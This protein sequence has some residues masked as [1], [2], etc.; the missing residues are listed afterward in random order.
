VPF[1]LALLAPGSDFDADAITGLGGLSTLAPMPDAFIV[2]EVP[3]VADVPEVGDVPEVPELLEEEV[4]TLSEPVAVQETEVIAV[5]TVA[6]PYAP[7]K[8]G[9]QPRPAATYAQPAPA[10]YLAAPQY[11]N[12]PTP[13]PT[14]AAPV[15]PT[16][17]QQPYPANYGYPQNYM[18]PPPSR[19][20]YE[21]FSIAALIAGIA[22]LTLVPGLGALL[23]IV[24]GILGL[25]HNR[26]HG[27]SSRGMAIAG[28]VLGALGLLVLPLFLF[29]LFARGGIFDNPIWW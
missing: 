24:F 11:A 22:G 21:P 15:A 14:Y 13:G 9:Q 19:A 10:P 17:Y 8:P 1:W 27:Q 4:V 5:A 6:D 7:P 18:A 20:N 2:P 26:E 23:A 12:T 3:E 29:L 25:H 16:A 28:T